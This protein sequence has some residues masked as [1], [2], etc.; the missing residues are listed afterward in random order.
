MK[1]VLK[2]ILRTFSLASLAIMVFSLSFINKF[3]NNDER[4]DKK[5]PQDNIFS[6]FTV[7]KV[8]ADAPGGTDLSCTDPSCSGDGADGAGDGD[9]CCGTG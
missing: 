9:G 1:K 5:N 6:S 4:G 8:F 2:I 7:N 3:T